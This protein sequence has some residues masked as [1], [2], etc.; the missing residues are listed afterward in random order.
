MHIRT[1]VSGDA[2][3]VVPVTPQRRGNLR[4]SRRFFGNGR[5]VA[6][7]PLDLWI[8]ADTLFRV[9]ARFIRHGCWQLLQ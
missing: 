6:H 5:I 9:L 2:L 7:L 8:A 1:R 4:V 3:G